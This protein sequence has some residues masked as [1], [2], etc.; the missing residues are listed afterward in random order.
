MFKKIGRLFVIK[1]KWEA[2][3]IIYALALGATARGSEYITQYPGWGGKLLFLATTGAVFLAGAKILDCL[4]YERE[5]R[6]VADV[7]Q[8]TAFTDSST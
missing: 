2:Y 1:T 4:R 5:A 6:E 8:P 7:D 3:L